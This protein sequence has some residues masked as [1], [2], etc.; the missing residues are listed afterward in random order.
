MRINS[1]KVRKILG[2]IWS[3]SKRIFETFFTQ[4]ATRCNDSIFETFF[5]QEATRCND[6]SATL[7]TFYLISEKQTKVFC[8]LYSLQKNKCWKI[9][10]I[11]RKL[12]FNYSFYSH[13]EI[14]NFRV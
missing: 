6:M 8:I 7:T 13:P 4:E 12:L 2:R 3:T 14:G 9:F 11:M 10:K 5:T 1:R